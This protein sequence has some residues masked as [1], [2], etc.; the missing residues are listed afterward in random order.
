[1][2]L[3]KL[4][5]FVAL[6]MLTACST[7]DVMPVDDAVELRLTSTIESTRVATADASTQAT[8][9]AQGEQVVVWVED[10][11]AGDWLYSAHPLTADGNGALSGEAMYVFSSS[12]DKVNVYA[13]HGGTTDGEGIPATVEHSVAVDQSAMGAAYTNS[14]LLFAAEKGVKRRG[15]PITCNLNFYHMLSKVEVAVKSG[16][17]SPVL[18]ETGGLALS[19]VNTKCTVAFDPDVDLAVRDNRK[20]LILSSEAP[21]TITMSSVMSADFSDDNVAYNEAIIVPQTTESA[22]MVFTLTDGST[23]KY[24]LPAGMEFESGKKY[25]FQITLDYTEVGFKLRHYYFEAMRFECHS[26]K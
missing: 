16:S 22:E 10:A 24:K 8:Q 9:L 18:A 23:F 25:R 15:N 7:D 13:F 21:G 17:G 5:P 12:V 19:G 1:M 3:Y 11:V 4:T 2:K 26:R 6:A 14:D 20:A